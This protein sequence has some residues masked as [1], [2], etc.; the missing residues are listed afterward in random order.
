MSNG[1]NPY[2]EM[3][4]I[5]ARAGSERAQSGA[6]R[7]YLGIVKS[8][9]PLEISV[10][11]TTQRAADGKMWCNPALLPD[12]LR[13]AKLSEPS[14]T[15]GAS[16]DCSMGAISQLTAAGSGALQAKLTLTDYGFDAGNHLLLLSRDMQTFFILCKEVPL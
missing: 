6:L 13:K 10:D 7:L 8:V 2:N 15:I 9:D 14:G 3:L 16:V 1:S 5:F 4:E 11:G 12:Y